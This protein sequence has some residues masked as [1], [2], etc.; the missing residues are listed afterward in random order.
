MIPYSEFIASKSRRAHNADLPREFDDGGL[1]GFQRDIVAWALARGRCAIFADTGLGKTRMQLR[2]AQAVAKASGGRVLILTPLAVAAQTT[3]EARRLGIPVAG[4][5][6]MDDGAMIDVVNYDYMHRL[7]PDNY[8]GIVLDESSIIKNFEAKTFSTLLDYFDGHKYKLCC[9]ATPSPNDH[10]ELG[11]HAEFL[12]VC[13]RQEMLAT[14]FVHDG[15]DTSK[16]RLKGHARERFWAWVAS[17]A[18]LVRHPR[19]LGYDC[20]G[21]DLPPLM[22]HKHELR[23][24]IDDARKS[25]FL[26]PVPAQSLRER[27]GARCIAMNDRVGEIAKIVNA[28]ASREDPWVVWCELNDESKMLAGSIRGS[29][30]IRGSMTAKEK[31]ERLVAFANGSYTAIIS[32]P[33]ICGFGLNWQHASNI[34]FCGLSDSYEQYYQ[35]IRRCWRFGQTKQ[36][37]V[38][39]FMSDIE[40]AV[41]AN[42]ERKA[43][44]AERM[45]VEL[46]A[47]TSRTVRKEIERIRQ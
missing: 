45:T 21:Y 44:D 34:V 39:V 7:N 2:W 14:Y 30:E 29:V 41:F 38:H 12:G 6:G 33:R 11:Q 15:G 46:S 4:R 8:S 32:K 47:E 16:W 3:Q 20:P 43:R 26:F 9:S 1:S 31:E 17:W 37:N 42:I 22:T 27:R 24:S 25:G 18:A 13:S 35:S 19:D 10:T 28:N 5:L 40:S 36:V 23:T